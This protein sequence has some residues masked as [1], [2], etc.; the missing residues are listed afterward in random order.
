MRE[1]LYLLPG[2]LCDATIWAPQIAALGDDYDIRV[3]DLTRYSSLADM[4]E[5]VLATAPGQISVAGHSMGAR[6]TLEMMRQAP[7]RIRRLALLDTG[8]HPRGAGEL[9]KRQALLDIS[10]RHGMRALAECWL[11]PMVLPENFTAGGN[12]RAALFAMVERMSPAIH[13]AQITALLDRPD[14]EPLLATITCPVLVGVGDGDV[15]SPP[16][17]HRAIAHAI[18]RATYVVFPRSGHMA[19]LEAPHAVTRALADWMAVPA[20]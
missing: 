8:V 1:T 16:E 20:G 4:A 17:Q 6:V 14:A 10:A 7:A 13:Q 11:P 5:A 19:P 2:L 15:W 18:P 3:P 12:L 9:E